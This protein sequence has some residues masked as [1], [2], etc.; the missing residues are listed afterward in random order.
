M[1]F[2]ALLHRVDAEYPLIVAANRDEYLDRGGL[3]PRRL[4]P[5]IV[6]GQD[7]RA[8]GAWLVVDARAGRMAAVTNLAQTRHDP[9]ARSRGLLC[10]DALDAGCETSLQDWLGGHLESHAYNGFILLLADAARA[11]AAVYADGTLDMTTFGPGIHFIGNTLPDNV[12][13]P[14]IARAKQLLSPPTDRSLLVDLLKKICGDHGGRTDGADAIC[15]HGPARG[16]LSSTA[17]ALHADDRRRDQYWFADGPPCRTAYRDL[18]PLL[19]R[20]PP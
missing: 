4:R 5:G 9:A 6:G 8:G 17:L 7:P 16:T 11:Q 20:E 2:I 1:C 12:D 3:P 19:R 10:L 18:S 15:I 14:K 13:E